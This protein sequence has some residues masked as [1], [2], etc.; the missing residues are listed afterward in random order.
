[1]NSMKANTLTLDNIENF[2]QIIL[3]EERKI[4]SDLEK[5]S[6]VKCQ[7]LKKEGKFFYYC[8]LDIPS[9]LEKRLNPSNQIYQR[10]ID[11]IEM[12]LY[13]MDNFKRCC[14]Y[15]GILKR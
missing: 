10:Y 8:S 6:Q 9:N 3:Q 12:Q 4:I 14:F 13:C 2:D 1:M 11:V 7:H 15:R 5:K